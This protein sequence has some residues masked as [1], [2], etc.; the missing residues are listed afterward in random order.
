MKLSPASEAVVKETAGVVAEIADDATV[1]FYRDMFEAHPELLNVFNEANQAIGE[2]PKALAASVVAFA[3]NLIDPDAPDF[4]PIMQRIAHKHVSLGISAPQY[5]IVGHYLLG[6]V[7]KVL[8][9]AATPE[10][11]AAWDEVY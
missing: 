10:I 1:L 2:Q 4:T 7:A 6:A 5:L 3:V 11:A 9:D 8:G